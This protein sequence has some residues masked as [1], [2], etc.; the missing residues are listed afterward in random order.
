MIPTSRES[1][2]VLP[3]TFQ[4]T[5]VRCAQSADEIPEDC[6]VPR[7]KCQYGGFGHPGC[8]VTTVNGL[9]QNLDQKLYWGFMRREPGKI[10]C[11]YNVGEWELG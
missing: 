8:F 9:E 3:E 11:L 2:R 6:W 1:Q 7:Y 5:E 10:D 4:S